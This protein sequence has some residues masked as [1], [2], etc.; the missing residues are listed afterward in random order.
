M[1]D[2]VSKTGLSDAIGNIVKDSVFP[3][4]RLQNF[5]DEI[6]EKNND[7]NFTV[8]TLPDPTENEGRQIYVSDE[9]GGS[10]LAFSDSINWR[11]VQ[12]RAIVS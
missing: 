9:V 10:T 2:I 1:K 12:D 11:R 4:A 3:S 8:A 5:F 6:E 7:T